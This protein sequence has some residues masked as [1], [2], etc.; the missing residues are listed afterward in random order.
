MPETDAPGSTPTKPAPRAPKAAPADLQKSGG[1]SS[2]IAIAALVIALIATVLAIFGW[3]RPESD[4]VTTGH[5][6]TDAKANVCAVT[7]VVRQAVGIST[8]AQ[9][10]P[11]PAAQL[12]VA[13]NARLALYGG[14]G[15][16]RDVIDSEANAPKD[17][18]QAVL[19]Y[20]NTLQELSINYLAGAAPDDSVQ[21]PLRD[22]L[23]SQVESINQLC[24]Q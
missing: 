16:L 11:E 8:N 2:L 18:K 7:G 1:L 24:Q 22:Q 21:Q 17:L 10:P 6:K 13:A 20:A 14:G 9:A 4:A 19:A 3:F 5:N 12:A 23:V 15:Y